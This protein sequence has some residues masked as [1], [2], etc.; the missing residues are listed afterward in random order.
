MKL[1]LLEIWGLFFQVPVVWWLIH[2]YGK[3][4]VTGEMIAAAIIGVVWEVSTEP[5]WDYHFKITFYHH[6][7]VA[8]I[9]GWMVMLT[10]IVCLSEKMYK[11][12]LKKDK[13]EYGDKRIFIFDVLSAAVIALPM[14][15][16]GAKMGVWSYQQNLLKWDW[17]LIPFFN[18]PYELLFGYS[19]LMLI[20]PTFIR[21]WEKPFVESIKKHR[22]S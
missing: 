4:D 3:R 9:S 22:I 20:A 11:K 18:M 19:L 17:G 21:Y 10:M 15:T 1:I 16:I 8:V 14:E 12:L 2:R 7:P 5:L 6:A 13:V